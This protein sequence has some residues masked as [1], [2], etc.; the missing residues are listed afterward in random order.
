MKIFG[1]LFIS[2]FFLS[3]NNTP[4]VRN[5]PNNEKITLKD[6]TLK[7]KTTI[8]ELEIKHIHEYF[9]RFVKKRR[10]NGSIAIA[11]NGQIVFDTISGFS[12][13]RRRIKLKEN[14]VQQLAS[15][16]KPVTAT[17]VLQLVEEGKLKLSDT[18]TQFLSELPEHYSRL[19]IKQLLSHRSGL[20]QYYYFC[21]HLMDEREKLIYNDTVLCVMNFH[22]PD[23]H[24]KPGKRYDYC[25]TNYL[26]LASIIEAI[27]KKSYPNVIKER[28]LDKCGMKNSFVFN[29]KEDSVPSNLVYGH[30]KWNKL[31]EFDYLDGIVGDKGLFSNAKE[32]L[33]F[34]N[35]LNN[36]SLLNDSTINLAFTPHNKIKH[37]K[38]YGL[39]WRIR[40]HKKLGKIIYHTGWW[41]GNRNIYI[42]IPKNDYTIVILS[43]ALRG[44][45]YN[46]NDILEHFTYDE[47]D[48]KRENQVAL[49]DHL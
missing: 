9:T 49:F 28:I 1:V 20:S 26:L 38:S 10:F 44:S 21:D 16:T 43:N 40:H 33:L 25:N 35:K 15:I 11:K 36:G 45:Q 37:G 22:N 17:V 48:N 46:M 19:T 32:M 6:T 24:F 14:S 39:G 30:T 4:L 27:E 41:H 8:P 18:I 42:K 29:C 23:P 5:E 12:N 3:C 13:V 34:D 47:Y 7:K 31:F 2:L